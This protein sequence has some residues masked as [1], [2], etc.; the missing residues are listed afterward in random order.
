[1]TPLEEYYN[2]FNEDKR[3]LSRHGQVEY[4]VTRHFI[5]ESI[6]RVKDIADGSI[7]I[8]DI[9][10][11]TGRYSI[12]LAK[13][14]YDVTA[15]E[16]VR[17]NLGILKKHA[18]E[19]GL[20]EGELEAYEGDARRLKKLKENTFDVTLLLGPMYHLHSIDDKVSAMKE[21]LRIT[22]SGGIILV[23]YVMADYAVIKH[24]FMEH[25]ILESVSKEAL[26]EDYAVKSDENELYDYVRISDI[27]V[28][29]EQSG[30]KRLKIVSPDGPAD[31]IRPILNG[32][33]ERE[34]E[35][36]ID[37]QIKNAERAE[38]VGAGSHTVDIV[39]KR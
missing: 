16:K 26:T 10:A 15:V 7:K 35:L 37:Y 4:A 20:A 18:R 11:G 30:A 25:N 14:G 1:M 9:G 17:Y 38:L 34:F 31:Y 5:A 19:E 36:F 39:T 22:K 8:A 3:L 21:A 33:S 27:D 29:N 6:G 32:M 28:I 13:E 2:K 12:A 23:G 24:G